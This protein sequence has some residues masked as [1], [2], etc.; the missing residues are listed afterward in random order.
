MNLSKILF[1]FVI[2]FI[3]VCLLFGKN[4]KIKEH[5]NPYLDYTRAYPGTFAYKPGYGPYYDPNIEIG[6]GN[7]RYNPGYRDYWYIP[8]HNYMDKWMNGIPREVALSMTPL[9]D[10]ISGNC[11]VPPSIS[12]Y[13]VNERLN[14]GEYFDDAISRCIVPYSVSESC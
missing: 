7:I 11:V 12:E 3:I 6:Y 13:C 8:V 14:D 5:F 4:N 10:N 2:V 1:Y 9:K